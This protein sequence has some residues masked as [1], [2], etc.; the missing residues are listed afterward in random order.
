M[1]KTNIFRFG[2]GILLFSFSMIAFS[3]GQSFSCPYGKEGACL[4]FGA[5]VCSS[6]GKCV[7]QDATC[8]AANTCYPWNEF[9]CQSDY[10]KLVEDYNQLLHNY[11]ELLA[12]HNNL[13]DDYNTLRSGYNN[14]NNRYQA[15]VACLE[16]SVT[17]NDY[18]SCYY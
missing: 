1:S 9:V 10:N 3:F 2:T 11:N 5:Q 15:I 6:Q 14:L 7:S 12:K 17:V 16:A 8:F 13:V 4:D 18:E